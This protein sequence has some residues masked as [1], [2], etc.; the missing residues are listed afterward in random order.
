MYKHVNLAK[1]PVNGPNQ[2]MRKFDLRQWV[3]V[4][5]F[6]PLSVFIYKKAYLRLCGAHFDL[7]KFF[8]L[9]RH[10]SNYSIQKDSDLVMSSDDFCQILR[11][12]FPD[13]YGDLTWESH[14]LP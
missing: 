11:D 8:D 9:Q 6:D 2:D 14:F 3:F 5:S 10:L 12:N 1:T 7:S 13:K 4:N